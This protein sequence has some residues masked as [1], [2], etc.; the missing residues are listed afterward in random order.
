MSDFMSF[1]AAHGL[2]IGRLK[3]DGKIHRCPTVEKP[4]SDNG[5]Y[6]L[7][8][9]RGWIQDWAQGDSV[10]WWND[11]HAKPWT[12]E[13]QR[14]AKERSRLQQAEIRR[15]Q[16]QVAQDA[17]DILA[18]A[19]WIIP[20]KDE[21]RGRRFIEGVSGHPYLVRKGFPL[22]PHFAHDGDLLVPMR[23]ALDY[24]TVI[25][26]QRIAADGDKKFMTGQ[27]AR[28]GIFRFGP[29]PAREVWLCEGFVTMLSTHAALKRLYRPAAVVAC[30]SAGNLEYVASR[31]IGTHVMAD[32]DAS[33]T[34]ERAAQATGLPYAIPTEV[35][36][37]ANDVHV[38]HGIEAVCELV[39]MRAT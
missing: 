3:A 17:A 20:S 39:A 34:G 10:Q 24:Q 15:R 30:F 1:A 8:G 38:L 12:P 32:R 22:E 7:D 2:A 23:D 28:G 19:E 31:G 25:G 37:D 9:D 14:E 5:A 35:G 13:Q 18:N 29:W 21:Q 6:L 16:H 27:R 11:P 4:R 26:L 36:T 33:E